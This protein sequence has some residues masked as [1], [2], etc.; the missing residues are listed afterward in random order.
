MKQGAGVSVSYSRLG[1]TDLTLTVWEGRTVFASNL[2]GGARIEFGE[3]D[4][5]IPVDDLTYGEPE[6]GDRVTQTLNGESVVFEVATPTTG[7]P[8]WRYADAGRTFYRLHCKRVVPEVD[9]TAP[10]IVSATVGQDG[11]TLTLTFLEEVHEDTG[12]YAG[13]TLDGTYGPATCTFSANDGAGTLT[14]TISRQIGS[15]ETITLDYTPGAVEDRSNNALAA[16]SAMAVTNNSEQE[17]DWTPYALD[18]RALW[19]KAQSSDCFSDNLRATPCS[20]GD[21]VQEWVEYDDAENFIVAQ[22][23]SGNRPTFRQ[24]T[25]IGTG[26]ST[27]DVR[28]VS[29]DYLTATGTALDAAPAAYTVFL[30]LTAD[31]APGT[32]KTAFGFGPN[33]E[34]GVIRR[35]FSGAVWEF[36]L[37]INGSARQITSATAVATGSRVVVGIVFDSSLGSA[38]FKAYVG[39]TNVGS[40][41]QSG[42]LQAGSVTKRLLTDA[43]DAAR[44]WPGGLYE[45]LVLKDAPTA[46]ELTKLTT[47][48]AG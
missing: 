26:V 13:F 15:V 23:T 29:D 9:T 25:D 11:E 40:V 34:R 33:G 37:F 1:E 42:A 5:L 7:E 32:G 6:L 18:N 45:V 19:L 22:G 46:D 48:L 16:V 35:S 24:V 43:F 3:R 8:C 27:Y 28:G 14:F 17:G 30:A 47:Y 38:Q 20:N 21:L 36:I 4:Y 39:S 31:S 44:G 41:T 10:T 12:V 2:D